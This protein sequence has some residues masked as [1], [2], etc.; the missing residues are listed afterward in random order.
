M[1]KSQSPIGYTSLAKMKAKL[2]VIIVAL[3]FC[4]MT[5]SVAAQS[6][7]EQ[8]V[9]EP[10]AGLTDEFVSE[11]DILFVYDANLLNQLPFTQFDWVSG[12]DAY[13]ER[14]DNLLDMV[15][16]KIDPSSPRTEVNSLLGSKKRLEIWC[17]QAMRIRSLKH[18]I[19][20]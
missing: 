4:T 5:F 20:V 8:I 14:E 12:K 9:L 15:Q 3:C 17:T 16:F 7:I 1:S 13:L 18:S 10:A 2:P 6:T 11:V 19:L